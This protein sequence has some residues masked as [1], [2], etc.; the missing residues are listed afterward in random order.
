MEDGS[1]GVHNLSY[2]V[3]LL[4]ASIADLTGDTNDDGLPDSWQIQ[5]FG[6]ANSPMAAPNYVMFPNGDQMPNWLKYS[7]GLDPTV[8]GQAV[9]DGVVWASG[10]EVGNP[11]G[12]NTLHIYTA[13]EVAFDTQVGTN[14]YIQ[15]VSSLSAGWKTIAGPIAGTGSQIS[16]VTPTRKDVQQ[17]FRV[18]HNP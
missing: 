5:Y 3:G 7:L 16:Y 8:P 6:S 11:S 18:Y 15:E 10:K 13:A 9:P 4:K 17:Y 12:T 14:Y 2:A 1:Y